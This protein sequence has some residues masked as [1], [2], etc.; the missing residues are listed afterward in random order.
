MSW[1][2]QEK[3]YDIKEV[4]QCS[5][6]D[7]L[8]F[9]YFEGSNEFWAKLKIVGRFS[10]GLTHYFAMTLM[11]DILSGLSLYFTMTYVLFYGC[12]TIKFWNDL[13]W[14]PHDLDC[15]RSSLT[16]FD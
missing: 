12:P 2:S 1:E 11:L 3:T 5:I 8:T 15:L 16:I 14:F 13:T 9:V 4:L 7:L 6:T 10:V